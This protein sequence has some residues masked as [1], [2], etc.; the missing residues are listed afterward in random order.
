MFRSA[1]TPE[2]QR[3]MTVLGLWMQAE[4][5]SYSEQTWFFSDR[6]VTF[7]LWMCDLKPYTM[8]V[9]WTALLST[10]KNSYIPIVLFTFI[11]CVCMCGCVY[12][13]IATTKRK[14]TGARERER[15]YE[16]IRFSSTW[17]LHTEVLYSLIRIV[18]FRVTRT[19]QAQK[20]DSTTTTIAAA[21]A[22]SFPMNLALNK[23]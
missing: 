15:E 14:R 22:K 7:F 21:A 17:V 9:Y 4:A 19:Q 23:N 3:H 5:L 1:I 16:L 8:P 12:A 2:F 18:A 6:F 13:A 11:V 20:I 10:K